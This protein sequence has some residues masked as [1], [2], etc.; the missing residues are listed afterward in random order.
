MVDSTLRL[1]VTNHHVVA[2][3]DFVTVSF[4]VSKNGKVISERSYYQNTKNNA[5]LIRAQVIDSDPKHDLALIL[6]DSL[7]DGTGQ[8]NLAAKGAVPG[9]K[10]YTVGNPAP[11]GTAQASDPLWM[12][13]DGKVSSVARQQIIYANEGQQLDTVMLLMTEPINPGDSGGSVVN[14]AGEIVGIISGG[15]PGQQ[16]SVSLAVELGAIK[17]FLPSA[18]QW[19]SPATVADYQKRAA[20]YVS[21]GRYSAAVADYTVLLKANP[22]DAVSYRN[23]A[24]AHLNATEWRW[25]SPTSAR[26]FVSIPRTPSPLAIAACPTAIWGNTTRPS[27]T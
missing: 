13:T 24:E 2:K 18:K 6:L 1:M 19:L 7:P 20:H 22:N 11:S 14:R 26:P 15:R 16:S 4:P 9:D 17:T 25:P 21:V 10:V 8:L 12:F 5:P 23:R 27:P 3:A